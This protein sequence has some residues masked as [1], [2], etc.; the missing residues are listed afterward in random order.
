MTKLD[1]E[2]I[3]FAEKIAGAMDKLK[4]SHAYFIVQVAYGKVG[5]S[6]GWSDVQELLN[7]ILEKKLEFKSRKEY[8]DFVE[9][10]R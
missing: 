2:K 4:S 7:R 1:K 6:M 8:R 9:G 5:E 10:R 3:E